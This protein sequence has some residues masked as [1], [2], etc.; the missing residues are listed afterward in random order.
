MLL[1]RVQEDSISFHWFVYQRDNH[2]SMDFAIR[3][4]VSVANMN[5]MT[6]SKQIH[7]SKLSAAREKNF[8]NYHT[9]LIRPII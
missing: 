6:A 8:R 5:H 9:M 3:L 4:V 2:S 1:V 7:N